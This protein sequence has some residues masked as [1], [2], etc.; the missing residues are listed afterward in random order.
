MG[1]RR[2]ADV[3]LGLQ[4]QGLLG[5]GPAGNLFNNAQLAALTRGIA[6]L[7]CTGNSSSA[8][9]GRTLAD[10]FK[11][12]QLNARVYAQNNADA[13]KIMERAGWK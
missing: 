4:I 6:T 5:A 11:E 12:D 8:L 10:N 2:Q 1:A 7:A 3:A 9:N 13:L